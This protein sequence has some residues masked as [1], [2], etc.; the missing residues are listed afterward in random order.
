MKKLPYY[1]LL[2]FAIF[3]SQEKVFAT[4]VVGAETSYKCTSTP[5]IFEVTLILYRNCDGV[6]LCFG[7]CGA[8]CTQPMDIIGNDPSCASVT[9]GSI[10]LS[11]QSVRDVTLN[12]S[13]PNTKNTCTNMGCVTPGS[14]TPAIERYEFK[15]LVN[16][17]PTS[18]IPASCCNIRLSWQL[19]CRS[20]QIAT[21]APGANFY[22]DAVI[23]RC[24]SVAPCNSSPDLDEIPFALCGG[25]S[26]VFNAGGVDPDYDSVSVAFAPALMGFNSSVTYDQPWA[27]NKPMPWTGQWDGQ[28]PAGIRCEPNGQVMFTPTNSSGSNW[29]GVV[30]FEIKQ[31]KLV[32]G[33]QTV[34]GITRRDQQMIVLANC[35]PNNVPRLTTEPP[36][37]TNPNAPRVNW[38]VCAGHQLCFDIMAKDTDFILPTISDTT[39]LTWNKALLSLGATFLPTYNPADRRKPAPLGGPREDKYQFCW[40]PAENLASASP[41]YFVVSGKDNRCPNPGTVSRAFAIKVIPSPDVTLTASGDSCG[42]W[43]LGY[44]KNKPSQ[45]ITGEWHVA[46]DSGDY[47]FANGYNV[48]PTTAG[49]AKAYFR[50]PGKYLARF[51]A[52]VPGSAT[53]G[54]CPKEF[55]D[56]L[57]VT[58]V[59]DLNDSISKTN[60]LCLGI[61]NGSITLKGKSGV[62]PYQYRLNQ[63]PYG[64]NAIFS[65]LAPGTYIAWVKDAAGCEIFDTVVIL[66]QASSPVTSNLTV[67]PA[68]CYQNADGQIAIIASGGT[69]PY[70]Y[71]L[72]AGAFQTGSVFSSL[73][74]GNYTVTVR[75]AN[76][77]ESIDPAEITSPPK[78]SDDHI[79][80]PTSVVLNDQKS[81]YIKA[82]PGVMY[83]WKVEK[84]TI[85]INND[86]A[87]GVSWDTLG[88]GKVSVTATGSVPA[89]AV[90]TTITITIGSTGLDDIAKQLGIEVF[91]NPA[92]TVL[93]VKRKRLPE[94]Q[95]IALYDVQGKMLLQ[96]QLKEEQQLNIE[97]LAK[98][99]YILKIGD[100]RGQIIKQ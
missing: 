64:T 89:C 35:P 33:V 16:L 12:S 42:K 44:T 96:Q 31:W 68:S 81:Y 17:G 28:F 8:T 26:A 74:R 91:P 92:T 95:T 71:R 41:Y 79:F 11:L 60:A 29:Y 87:I 49:G 55:D 34:V 90:T 67:I 66:Q 77:C 27:Y 2:L 36:S 94:E 40:T 23:N 98:G 50:K 63:E 88:T 30:A 1:L 15:G 45:T 37:Q 4:H 13:C 70:Q 6:D 24:L 93:N 43:T 56:T 58:V 20:T 25:E 19:C 86:S 65:N 9:F 18:G 5:G 61:N 38:E 99:V 72:D 47:T 73:Q 75:D 46:K 62:A 7:G 22:I 76:N 100:W 14:Y 53:T 48:L 80:G 39:Y 3:T 83:T 78:V 82:I 54:P 10:S 51:V 69:S 85:L 52:Y 32:N 57:D 21:V 97:G 84:G 59:P